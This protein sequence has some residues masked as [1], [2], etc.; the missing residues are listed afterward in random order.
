MEDKQPV[1]AAGQPAEVQ[2]VAGKTYFFCT[3]GRSK[4]QPFCDGAHKDTGFEPHKFT[5][6]EDGLA[7][8]CQCKHTK[9]RPFCDGS[10][11]NL[12]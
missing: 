12:P 10:H 5:A 1:I 3:C 2:L 7:W 4:K 9:D 8:L 6:E 11:N